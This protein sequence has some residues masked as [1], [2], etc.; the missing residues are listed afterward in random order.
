MV[1][2]TA[3]AVAQQSLPAYAHRFSP[4]KF[5]QHQLFA[6]LVLKSMLNLDYRGVAAMLIDCVELRN[7]I[8]LKCV[9][10]FTTLQKAAARLLLQHCA[11]R[12]HDE[13]IRMAEQRRILKP[14][15]ALAAIDASGF[16]AH[17]S[18]RYFVR[19][20]E[21]GQ[22]GLKNPLYQTTTYRRFPK[23]SIVVDRDSHM[24]LAST[25]SRGPSPDIT[26]LDRLMVDAI[27]RRKIRVAVLDAGYDAEWAH[28]LLRNDMGI[29]SIIPPKIGRRTTRAPTGY[30]RAMMRRRFPEKLYGQRW[31]AETAFS[32]IKRRQGE[33][34][35]AVSYHA[36]CRSIMLKVLTH[37]IMI[38][39]RQGR[40]FLR[41]RSNP[42]VWPCRRD[43]RPRP[44][45][46]RGDRRS[47]WVVGRTLAPDDTTDQR[48]GSS[49]FGC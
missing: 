13:T 42:F 20:R 15:T 24:I 6:C 14:T 23:A 48:S 22:K 39:R 38:I 8:G 11:K 36:Q 46:G 19:R 16:E 37:N 25:A 32:M 35:R 44:L 45:R 26:Q 47:G 7:A 1:I 33:S 40:G 28:E 27:V 43:V 4:T 5:T 12:L 49:M 41:S 31:Q 30:Y 17:H 21:R 2:T 3:Y 29:R 18:S 9:P 10:H 34:V